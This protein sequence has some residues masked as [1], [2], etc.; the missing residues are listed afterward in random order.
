MKKFRI[1]VIDFL[2]EH[3]KWKV[4]VKDVDGEELHVGDTVKKGDYEFII[5]YRYGKFV[6][7]PPYSLAY[8][9]LTEKSMVKKLNNVTTITDEWLIIGYVDEPFYQEIKH[10]PEIQY[11]EE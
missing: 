11:A 10:L 5:A 8:L 3:S 2:P 9:I 4:G 1:Q 7:K 6:L